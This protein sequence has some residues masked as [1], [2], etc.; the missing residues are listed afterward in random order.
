[1]LSSLCRA[2]GAAGV[3]L[4]EIGRIAAGEGVRVLAG[5]GKTLAFAQGSYSH[6]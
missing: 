2:S 3:T 6:F 5:D 4:T 1:M